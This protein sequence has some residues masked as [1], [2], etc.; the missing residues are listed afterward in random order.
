MQT[1]FSPTL[2]GRVLL[3]HPECFSPYTKRK[4]GEARPFPVL[5]QC[6]E[7]KSGYAVRHKTSFTRKRT[8]LFSCHCCV[9]G[10]ERA[11]RPGVHSVG[12]PYT[13]AKLIKNKNKK[14]QKTRT[15]GPCFWQGGEGLPPCSSRTCK[16]AC[17][18]RSELSVKSRRLHFFC[19]FI[20]GVWVRMGLSLS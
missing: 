13:Y 18:I 14:K 7:G 17:G 12:C 15:N 5:A 19:C 2:C 3:L 1:K 11:D 20:F 4:I 8:D 10:P 9:S 16:I 6:Y